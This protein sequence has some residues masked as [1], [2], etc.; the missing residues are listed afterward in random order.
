MN[1]RKLAVKMGIMLAVVG[2]FGA[3]KASAAENGLRF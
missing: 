2:I 3:S 1:R